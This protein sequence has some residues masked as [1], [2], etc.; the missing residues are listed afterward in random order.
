MAR[1][2]A[3]TS[4]T[5]E[6]T[7]E[8][9]H[10]EGGVRLGRVVGAHGL[11]GELRVRAE[12]DDARSLLQL[13]TVRLARDEEGTGEAGSQEFAIESARMGRAGECRLQLRGIED[14]DTAEGWRG[15]GVF[16]RAEDLPEL[17]S[18]EFYAYE[19]VGCRVTRSDGSPIGR[20]RE[21]WETGANDVLVIEDASG[22]DQLVPAVEPL[23]REIDVAGRHIVVDAPPGLLEAGGDEEESGSGEVE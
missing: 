15:A 21:I 22:R 7:R 6:G 13:P 2:V 9:A 1:A 3:S 23:L 16:G 4:S 17:S 20:V 12:G 19:L 11:R 10:A 5:R 18:G 14:R 8:R